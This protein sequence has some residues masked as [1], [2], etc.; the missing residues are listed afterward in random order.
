MLHD[1]GSQHRYELSLLRPMLA[2]GEH[3]TDA[4]PGSS[5]GWRDGAIL[6]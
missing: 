1:Y 5:Q 6:D 3:L 4:L 2:M